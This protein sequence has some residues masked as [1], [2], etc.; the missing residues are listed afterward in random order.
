MGYKSTHDL[1]LHINENPQFEMFGSKVL[2][3]LSTLSTIVSEPKKFGLEV[4]YFW[5]FP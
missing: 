3:V 5:W 4:F 2:I 1:P